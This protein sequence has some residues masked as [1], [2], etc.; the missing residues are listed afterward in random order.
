MGPANFKCVLVS[1][2]VEITKVSVRT[3]RRVKTKKVE[4]LITIHVNKTVWHIPSGIQLLFTPLWTINTDTHQ[5]AHSFLDDKSSTANCTEMLNIHQTSCLE[6]EICRTHCR[7][8]SRK[9]DKRILEDRTDYFII[10]QV[11]VIRFK[12]WSDTTCQLSAEDNFMESI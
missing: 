4:S 6:K 1:M 11:K 9:I 8:I 7:I 3:M 10:S 12:V 2:G 5:P